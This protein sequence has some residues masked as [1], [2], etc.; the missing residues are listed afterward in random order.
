ME[1]IR[2]LLI[3]DEDDFRQ[4]L[5]KRLAKRG[6]AV[7]QAA[8]GRQGLAMLADGTFDVVV[9]DVKMPEMSGIEVL[10]E[11]K[12][13]RAPVEVILLTGHA[14]T[15]TGVEGIKS[16]AFDYL[17]K[18]IELDHLTTKIAQAREKILRQAAERKEA[19]YRRKIEQQM[20]ATERLAALGTLATGVAHEINNPLAIIGESAGWMKQLLAKEEFTALPRKEDFLR[21]LEKVEKSVE[22]ARRITH[23]LLGFVRKSDSAFSEVNLARLVDESLQLIEHE[24]R[25]RNIEIILEIVSPAVTVCSDPFRIRQSLINLLTNA[26]QAI[27][28]EG[29]ITLT[30]EDA[31][32]EAAI[33]VSDTGPGIPPENMARI[34]EPFFSTKAPGEGT[35]LGLFVTRGVIE[36]LGGTVSVASEIGRGATFR[37]RLPK[38]T[39][40]V[41]EWVGGEK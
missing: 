1:N 26:V 10:R 20:I 16:G 19:E 24:T 13:R 27:G 29:K 40:P 6:Y 34:F 39:K 3:D 30:L 36:K 25:N 9:L 18:P 37:I 14:T 38:Q 12:A 2:L 7:D 15:A 11:I 41:A 23:Q 28:S 31:G 21:A 4:T 17:T 33:T 5:A 8:D 22:R 35:G 32:D